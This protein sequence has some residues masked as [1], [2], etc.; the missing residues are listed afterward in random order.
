MA[1]LT[2]KQETFVQ[3]HLRDGNASVAY[4]LAYSAKNMN[5]NAVRVEANRL[6]N[7]PNISLRITGIQ[8]ATE[9]RTVM[10]LSYVLDSFREIRDRCLTSVP[11]LAPSGE[12]TGEYTFNAAGANK[13]ME[14]IGRL[15]GFYVERTEHKSQTVVVDVS[16]LTPEE[17]E[18]FLAL[19]K[20]IKGQRALPEAHTEE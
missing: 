5:D 1:R 20:A 6:L 9:Q 11:V 12:E 8:A 18:H 14:N 13:A 15:L 2:P 4:R 17:R 10:D 7:N 16:A 19:G 3:A